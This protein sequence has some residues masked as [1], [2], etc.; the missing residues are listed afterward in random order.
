MFYL[1]VVCGGDGWVTVD[2]TC[3]KV[4]ERSDA[5]NWDEARDTCRG[6]GADLAVLD[7]QAKSDFI[8]WKVEHA[9]GE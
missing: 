6:L 1:T 2:G 3:M 4:I 8:N 9:A 7:T 5:Q